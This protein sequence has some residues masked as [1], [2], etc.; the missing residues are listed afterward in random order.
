MTFKFHVDARC[1]MARSGVLDLPHAKVSTCVFMQVSTQAACKGVTVSQL[2]E[3]GYELILGNT[4]HL[5]LRPGEQVLDAHG[6]AHG[7]QGWSRGMLSD[8]GGFQMVSLN[9]LTTITEEGVVMSSTHGSEQL[10]LR[11]EDSIRIQNAI[12]TDIMMQLDDC[13]QT[14]TEPV[15]AA[16]AMHRSIRWLD[17]CM[18]A[19][20]KP[21]TCQVFGIIQGC[22]DP[23]LRRHCLTEMI[24]RD[25]AGYAI[26]GLSG[27]E[28]KDQFWRTVALCTEVLQKASSDKVIYLMGVG[29]PSDVVVCIALGVDIFDCVYP[30]RTA[31]FGTALTSRGALQLSKKNFAT[32]AGPLDAECPCKICK[33]YSRAF[34]HT[35]AAKSEK[36][37]TLLTYHN[38][39][40]MRHLTMSAKRS[41]QEG[42]FVEFVRDFFLKY[43][44]ERDYPQWI[45]DALAHVNIQLA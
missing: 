11:P 9:S 4:Y 19:N 17:R 40:Y 44:P 13:V 14:L 8:S 3:I 33:R 1:G 41:I 2:E 32:D 23:E 21:E 30:T 18:A 12:G 29:V 36:G 31:R 45:I 43:H 42:R 16:E 20:Q 6:G 27:G 35:V 5:G 7:L 26:G 24:K 15:R 38:L 39:A 22:L 28:A 37:A 25:C 10:T 34:L